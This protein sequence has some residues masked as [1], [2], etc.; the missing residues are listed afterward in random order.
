MA[1]PLYTPSKKRSESSRLFAYL[2]EK[3]MKDYAQLHAYSVK[4]VGVFWTELMT[5]L[6]LDFEGDLTQA[7]EELSFTPY[8]WFP[9]VKLNA[10]KNY[11]KTAQTHP[12]KTAISFF[13]ES[14]RSVQYSYGQLQ[15]DVSRFEQLLTPHVYPNAVVAAYM[16]NIPE[17]VLCMLA[18]ASLGLTFT[19]TSCDFGISGVVDRFAQSKPAVLVMCTGYE[20]SGKYFDLTSKVEELLAELPS[21]KALILVDFLQKKVESIEI[22]SQVTLYQW[23]QVK[24]DFTPKPL[25]FLPMPFKSPFYIMY[26]SGTTGKPKCI[27]HSLGGTLL[28][29]YKEL[30]LHA[31]V[32]SHKKIFFFTTCGWMMWNWLVSAL[33]L[34]AEVVLYDGSPAYPSISSFMNNI[35]QMGIHIWGTSPKFLRAMEIE[36][37][38]PVT[39]FKSL[40]T[41]LSTGSPLL[42]EQYEFVYKLFPEVLLSSISGGTD[43]LSCFMLSNPLLPVYAGEIQCAGLGMSVDCFDEQG[44]SLKDKV[45]ELVCTTP[46]VS[47]PLYFLG[48]NQAQDKLHEAYFSVYK[49]TW[50]HGDFI[51]YTSRGTI[52]VYGRSDATLN[53]GGVR[54]G[55]GE[56]YRQ[57]E[58]LPWIVDSL[59]VGRE[60]SSGDVEVLLFVKLKEGELLTNEQV[61]EVRQW[62]RKNTTP[63]HMP[64][65]VF[66]VRDIPY[67]RSGKKVELA[68]RKIMAGKALN[69]LEAISNVSCLEDFYHIAAVEFKHEKK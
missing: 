51:E 29:H 15:D 37:Y 61:K 55:T 11:L 64:Q 24:K 38:R 49:H 32:D 22:K 35:D 26:S 43:I 6:G 46:F 44:Q 41:I 21:V 36:G 3:G 4:D 50:A 65:Y 28:Q 20:Y 7:Y 63:R 58:Q 17:T 31:D 69:N 54:I 62:I 13:H 25:A 34:G 23:P 10:A 47:Q 67:T 12:E 27:V 16:P 42:S 59:C 30:A 5:Y 2:T 66:Q 40:E 60:D 68:V 57:T 52:I 56:I 33:G 19:S 8:T 18:A 1:I 53:P 39:D 48:D 45:G 14:G 9:H